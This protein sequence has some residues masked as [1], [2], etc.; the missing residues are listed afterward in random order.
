MASIFSR[1][2]GARWPRG[3]KFRLSASGSEA[4]AKYQLALKSSRELGGR[5][6]FDSALQTW[7]SHLG[8][9]PGDGVYLCEL[10]AARS[11]AELL[12]ALEFSGTTKAEAKA[13][14]ERLV[15]AKLAEPVPLRAQ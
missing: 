13:A 12:A 3:Q 10:R 5:A 1:D 11:L 4:E 2:E 14:L 9:R 6:A 7:A 15:N 8:V